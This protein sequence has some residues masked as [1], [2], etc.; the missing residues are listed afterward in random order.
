MTIPFISLKARGDK[1]TVPTAASIITYIHSQNNSKSVQI[2]ESILAATPSIECNLYIVDADI[3]T[4]QVKLLNVPIPSIVGFKNHQ[5]I[6]FL[7][8]EIT[9]CNIEQFWQQLVSNTHI[10]PNISK[11]ETIV[12]YNSQINYKTLNI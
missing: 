4:I 6:S 10:R 7:K 12:N 5:P 9:P 1:V 8:S 2:L 3:D 11:I